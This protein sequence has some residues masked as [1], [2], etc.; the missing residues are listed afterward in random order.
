[1]F[2]LRLDINQEEIEK[3]KKLQPNVQVH[4]DDLSDRVEKLEHIL[5]DSQIGSSDAIKA[6]RAYRDIVDAVKR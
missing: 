3:I 6:A 2:G 1:M 5:S 4:A